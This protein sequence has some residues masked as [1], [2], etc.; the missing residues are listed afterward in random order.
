MKLDKDKIENILLETYG[1]IEVVR[2]S[3]EHNDYFS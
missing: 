3:C 1:F 2:D